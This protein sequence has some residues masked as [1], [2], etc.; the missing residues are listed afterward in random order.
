MKSLRIVL[1]MD[2][3]MYHSKFLNFI[4]SKCS[5]QQMPLQKEIHNILTSRSGNRHSVV[6]FC[7]P[8]YKTSCVTYSPKWLSNSHFQKKRG[9]VF[10]SLVWKGREESE[11]ALQAAF[12]LP[13]SG[14]KVKITLRLSHPSPLG[15][16]S[17]PKQQNITTNTLTT[18]E[19]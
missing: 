11:N 18:Q 15:V 1:Y 5:G 9:L 16:S 13:L 19:E 8:H 2:F 17:P 6:V 7:W 3:I 14:H 4:I 10:T 12:R